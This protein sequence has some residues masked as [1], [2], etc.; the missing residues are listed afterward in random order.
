MS[1]FEVFPIASFLVLI[2]LIAGRIIYL[3]KKGIHITPDKRKTGKTKILIN[4]VFGII[5]LLWFFELAKPFVSSSFSI[6]P[7]SITT[8]LTNSLPTKIAGI[9]IITVSLVLLL[10]TLLHF[11]KSLRFGLSEK[12]PGKLVTEGVFSFSRN[13]FFL[14]IDLYFFGV[15]ILLPNYFF[16]GFAFLTFVSIHFFI[17]KEEKFMRK[18]YGGAYENYKLK[19][20]RYL[21]NNIKE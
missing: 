4:T 20:R 12:N 11:N 8:L 3:K 9:S 13:P 1:G 18:V 5:M 19:V 7:E 6:L 10:F 21:G 16:I 15:A 17:L 14:S 2:I